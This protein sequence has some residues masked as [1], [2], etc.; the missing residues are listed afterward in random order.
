M[1]RLHRRQSPQGG[2]STGERGVGNRKD[3]VYDPGIW[4]GGKDDEKN[5][6]NLLD[7]NGI[8]NPG[9]V[10]PFEPH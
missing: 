2:T 1:R 7:A 5:Q 9:K 4:R 8:L 6:E 3:K 10:L